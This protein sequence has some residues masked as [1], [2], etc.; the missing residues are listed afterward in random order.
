MGAGAAPCGVSWWWISPI[1]RRR[2]GVLGWRLVCRRFLPTPSI[3]LLRVFK[4]RRASDSKLRGLKGRMATSRARGGPWTACAVSLRGARV[5]A[6]SSFGFP[7]SKSCWAGGLIITPI[8]GRLAPDPKWLGIA[9]VQRAEKGKEDAAHERRLYFA[10]LL[11]FF[12]P[13][14]FLFVKVNRY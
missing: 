3:G 6:Y 9:F 14:L 4:S 13:V 1:G 2:F 8:M 7:E 11:C 12:W 5:R 10:D